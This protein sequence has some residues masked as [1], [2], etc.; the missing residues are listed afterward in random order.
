MIDIEQESAV[1]QIQKYLRPFLVSHSF[2]QK[3]V[4]IS[5]SVGEDSWNL[6]T[7]NDGKAAYV[8]KKWF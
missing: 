5:E 8:K 1:K 7:Q 3:M 4:K 2:D 6:E